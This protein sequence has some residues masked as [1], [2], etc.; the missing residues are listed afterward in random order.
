[1]KKWIT[2]YGLAQND[3]HGLLEIAGALVQSLPTEKDYNW[4]GKSIVILSIT[5]KF[6]M[7]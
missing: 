3:L 4:V 1:M 2:F 5:D 6:N 7:G